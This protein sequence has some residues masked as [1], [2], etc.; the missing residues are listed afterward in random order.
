MR[1]LKVS[2]DI[3]HTYIGDLRVELL[4]PAGRRAILHSQL[5]GAQD[6]LAMTYDSAAPASVLA[7]F[8]RTAGGR[9]TGSCA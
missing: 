4:S 5:G 1:Q 7:A 3:T 9:A 8:A 6:N 2:V